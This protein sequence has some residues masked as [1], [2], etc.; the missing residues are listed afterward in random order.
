MVPSGSGSMPSIRLMDPRGAE[1]SI[2]GS[3]AVW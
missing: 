3:K 1:K 2:P